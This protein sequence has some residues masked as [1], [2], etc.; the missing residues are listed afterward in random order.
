MHGSIQMQSIKSIDCMCGRMLVSMGQWFQISLLLGQD[1]ISWHMAP[2]MNM[3]RV[4][5]LYQAHVP[6]MA[7]K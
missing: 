2:Q 5:S 1:R 7:A 4:S 6:F 3:E